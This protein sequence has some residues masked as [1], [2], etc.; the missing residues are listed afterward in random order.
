VP[1]TTLSASYKIHQK[2]PEDGVDRIVAKS[3]EALR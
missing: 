2:C 3:P 1:I